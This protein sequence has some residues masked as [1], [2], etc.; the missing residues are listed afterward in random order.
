MSDNSYPPALP[1]PQ[2]AP[3][4]RQ[5]RGN[6]FGIAAL[7]L[8]IVTMAG[9]AIPFLNFVT[10]GTG[11]AG[12]ALG[13]IGLMIKFRPRKAAIAGVILS[14]LGLILSIVLV[15]VYAAALSGAAK[16]F[17]TGTVPTFT[18]TGAATA[19]AAPGSTSTFENG[20]LTT[21]SLKIEITDHKVIPVGQPGNEYGDKPVIAFYYKTTNL[22]DKK[23]DPTTAFLFNISVYQDN[24]TNAV[25]KLDVGSLPDSKFRDSQLEDIKNGGT[26]ENA[27][28]YQLDDETTPV[29]LVA[30]DLFGDTPIG[31]VSYPLQ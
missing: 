12:L 21:P 31:K 25:N 8:G 24:N 17:D 14:A 9:F 22:T 11:V 16:A 29:D 30:A 26:V 5:T 20:V 19:D 23:L 7:V 2:S 27:L 10:I 15:I 13:I 18:P 6:G 28:A 3:E 4:S 1:V